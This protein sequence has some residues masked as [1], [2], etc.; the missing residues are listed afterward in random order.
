MLNL[1]NEYTA[2]LRAFC[3]QVMYEWSI[4]GEFNELSCK[5]VTE[6]FGFDA[7]ERSGSVVTHKTRIWEI[8]GSN[9]GADQ[10]DWGFFV[11]FLNHQ[12][13]CWV[14]FSLPQPI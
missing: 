9:P 1:C 14:G 12:G 4:R 5:Q 8:P 10:S 3:R 2:G 6:Y 7:T 11:V 13:K